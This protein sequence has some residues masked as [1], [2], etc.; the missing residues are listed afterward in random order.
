MSLPTSGEGADVRRAKRPDV[1]Q[2][3]LSALLNAAL[4]AVALLFVLGR[5]DNGHVTALAAPW[6]MQCWLAFVAVLAIG[7]AFR[8]WRTSAAATL[9]A[10]WS[11]VVVVPALVPL[12]ATH[13]GLVNGAERISAP[14]RVMSANVNLRNEPSLY[15]LKWVREQ[16]V[17]LFAVIEMPRA[18]S[19]ALGAMSADF[20]YSFGRPS[21]TNAAGIGLFS[22]FP[23][24][25][26]HFENTCAECQPFIDAIVD[27][28]TGPIRVLAIHP[29]S[30]MSIERTEWRDAELRRVAELCADRDIP[31]IIMGD[32]NE[33]P[34]GEAFNDL[35]R[36]TGYT[37]ART[38]KGF[39]PT[40]PSAR[41]AIE[42][43]SFLR[44]PIDHIVVSPHFRTERFDVGVQI[45]SDH[46]PVIA[47]L[48]LTTPVGG[49]SASRL[50]SAPPA[51]R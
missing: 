10:I 20:P 3:V 21:D 31:T 4:L 24:R 40:W 16:R 50:P 51:A 36:V 32:F 30:P 39:S 48:K 8:R 5:L 35:L 2:R 45:G 12:P 7:V 43:P 13:A 41:D 1:V 22:R 38:V 26:A 18:W 44:I 37:A 19:D 47:D 11:G 14:L 29:L 17:D 46:L 33:T 49:L 15:A 27:H 42:I 23:L 34:Y 6:A 9:L 28:P 25:E